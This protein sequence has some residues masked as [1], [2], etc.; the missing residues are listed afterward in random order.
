MAFTCHLLSDPLVHAA[1]AGR[2]SRMCL[3]SQLLGIKRTGEWQDPSPPRP[4]PFT[5][6][7]SLNVS[8]SP[9]WFEILFYL[10]SLPVTGIF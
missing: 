4:L 10:N 7:R 2:L 3:A 1:L 5:H 8:T 6:P 9:M